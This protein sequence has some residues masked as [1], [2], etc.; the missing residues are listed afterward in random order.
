MENAFLVSLSHLSSL[1]REMD[2]IA[3]NL[4]NVNTD[5]Y[6]SENVLFEEFISPVAE[7]DGKVPEVSFVLD[8]GLVRNLSAGNL[9]QTGS[10]LDVAISSDGYFA[11]QF[12]DQIAY[13]RNGSFNLNNKGELV[14]SA[15]HQVLNANLRPIVIPPGSELPDIASDGTIS[16]PG[17]GNQKLGVFSFKDQQALKK[18]GANLFTTGEERTLTPKDKLNLVQG[19]VESSNVQAVSEITRM[20]EVMRKYQSAAQLTENG[21]ELTR[22]AIDQLSRVR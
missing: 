21:D 11:V 18:I 10:P 8:Y 3:N 17:L 12:N 22:K 16:G 9:V 4:A 20:I 2:V 6:K 13:T 15:G 1:K 7:G 14:T 19:S 5:A